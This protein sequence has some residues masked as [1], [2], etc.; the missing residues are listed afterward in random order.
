MLRRV[1]DVTK[2][3]RSVWLLQLEQGRPVLEAAAQQHSRWPGAVPRARRLQLQRPTPGGEP[4]R[5]RGASEALLQ[6]WRAELP[7]R[8]LAGLTARSAVLVC[9]SPDQG[10]V[11]SHYPFRALGRAGA[12]RA[13][14]PC[15]PPFGAHRYPDVGAGSQR[16]SRTMRSASGASRQ[17]LQR[18]APNCLVV[19]GERRAWALGLPSLTPS[20]PISL[21]A[22]ETFQ[23]AGTRRDVLDTQPC[24]SARTVVR[25]WRPCSAYFHHSLAP[26][27]VR[28][29]RCCWASWTPCC[30]V[31]YPY[32]TPTA[33]RVR[34]EVLPG[35]MAA[36]ARPL[37]PVAPHLHT[38]AERAAL[39]G[40]VAVLL[41]YAL[42]FAPAGASAGAGAAA[43]A[44]A[45]A[46]AAPR[47]A[48]PAEAAEEVNALAPPVHRLT[49]FAVRRQGLFLCCPDAW[50]RQ[51]P[52]HS[53]RALTM[54]HRPLIG[55]CLPQGPA[56]AHDCLLCVSRSAILS[57][58][59]ITLP[60]APVHAPASSPCRALTDA[61]ADERWHTG[62]PLRSGR[63]QWQRYDVNQ[64]MPVSVQPDALRPGSRGR[65]SAR[66]AARCRPPCASW[67]SRRCRPRPSGSARRC[68]AA[69]QPLQWLGGAC[70]P[71]D[72]AACRRLG[73][74][75]ARSFPCPWHSRYAAAAGSVRIC[76][77]AW[78]S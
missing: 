41:G 60:P 4:A 21:P 73:G 59:S 50:A 47:G 65:A 62:T 52:W 54:W 35:I 37:R 12:R 39:A 78:V 46:L 66:S 28:A 43:A 29:R 74:V 34:Q 24:C 19:V 49:L 75:S 8:A 56:F 7:P 42:T 32:P 48:A 18:R 30:A 40:L 5:A 23:P 38:A 36:L 44:A 31:S 10:R 64:C 6:A 20:C 70:P 17:A 57:C 67:S 71:S 51:P 55:S 72:A 58:V 22:V 61:L 69:T 68:A 3:V 27:H 63:F 26:L 53:C 45:A 15:P 9:H 11:R 16:L 13:R 76:M 25:L 14:G 33:A 2:H 1:M 77:H